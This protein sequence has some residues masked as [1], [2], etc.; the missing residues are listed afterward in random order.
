MN[1]QKKRL[2]YWNGKVIPW[3]RTSIKKQMK[4]KKPSGKIFKELKDKSKPRSLKNV[5]KKTKKLDKIK[6]KVI[7]KKKSFI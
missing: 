7:K 6:K 2:S 5:K 4:P 3:L 1:N